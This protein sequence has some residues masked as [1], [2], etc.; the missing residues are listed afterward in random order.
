[1]GEVSKMH[2]LERGYGVDD[3]DRLAAKI[4]RAVKNSIYRMHREKGWSSAAS[5]CMR[6][7]ADG[8]AIGIKLN[9]I[10]SVYDYA[11]NV[12][13]EEYRKQKFDGR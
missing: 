9:L 4:A 7:F 13:V 12:L 1:M 5:W 11:E 3:V 10:E 2:L 6:V 8:D